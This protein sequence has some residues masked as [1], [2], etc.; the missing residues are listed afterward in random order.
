MTDWR[1]KALINYPWRPCRHHIAYRGTFP[2]KKHFTE[3]N[4][5]VTVMTSSGHV[6]SSGA[7][8]ACP[9]TSPWALSY[10][11]SIGTIPLSGCLSQIFS[12]E[13][14]TKIITWWRHQYRHKTRINYPWG[15]YRHTIS[16]W[17]L[18]KKKHF[19]EKNHDATIM[20]SSGHV[21]SS[22]VWPIDSP[23]TLS[24]RVS[25]GTIPLSGF[26]SDIFS[27][28]VVTKI[29]TWWRHLMTSSM[30]S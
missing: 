4:H 21:T 25:I 3:K 20:T 18:P 29:I 7:I 1:H 30:T 23:W 8:G 15:P 13:F 9:I 16:R 17:T 10:R 12:P 5:D 14:A 19:T 24:Y 22:G 26:I 2:E 6:T 27:P 28:K 11:L